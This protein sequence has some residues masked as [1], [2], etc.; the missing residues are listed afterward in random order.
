MRGSR[1]GILF[2]VLMLFSL[3]FVSAGL[4]DWFRA[5]GKVVSGN[6]GCVGT[7]C[8][9]YRGNEII[10]NGHLMEVYYIGDDFVS[11]RIDFEVLD[12]IKV[13]EVREFVSYKIKINKVVKYDSDY[14]KDWVEF[15]IINIAEDLTTDENESIIDE[16]I[17]EFVDDEEIEEV[18]ESSDGIKDKIKDFIGFDKDEVV[19]EP[20]GLI[21]EEENVS[22][23]VSDEVL[24]ASV[25]DSGVDLTVEQDVIVEEED[26]SDE[27][28]GDSMIDEEVEIFCDSGCLVEEKCYGYGYRKKAG[29]CSSGGN[30]TSQFEVNAT[31]INNFECASNVCIDERC[32]SVSA[33]ERFTSWLGG[34]F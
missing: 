18:N 26:I 16:K 9:L 21:V 10:A 4:F 5:T 13:L 31:C 29:Y 14:E 27:E 17:E 7:T 30:W 19:V 12:S 8:I 25:N 32:I 1:I 23:N 34:I 6:S 15:E 2:V 11:L 28:V 20:E 33:W 24:N 22:V 3:T